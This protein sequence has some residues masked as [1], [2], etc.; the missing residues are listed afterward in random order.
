MPE[1]TR[2]RTAPGIIFLEDVMK[3]LHL[4][5]TEA[6]KM[7]GISEKEFSDFINDKTTL[8][9]EMALRIGRFTNTSAE[10]WMNIELKRHC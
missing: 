10:S 6:A 1:M 5:V 2:K 4:S 9:P 8:S 7:L 3:P